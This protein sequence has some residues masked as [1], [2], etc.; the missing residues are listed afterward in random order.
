MILR[1][2]PGPLPGQTATAGSAILWSGIDAAPTRPISPER[3]LRVLTPFLVALP[4]FPDI[5]DLVARLKLKQ[6]KQWGPL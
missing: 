5:P 3:G 1:N 6:L 4:P 2:A